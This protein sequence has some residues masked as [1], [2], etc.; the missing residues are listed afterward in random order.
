MGLAN[1]G[2]IVRAL[3][4][5]GM[6]PATPA[7]LIENGTLGNQRQVVTRLEALS[8]AGFRGPALI[9][10]GAVVALARMPELGRKLAA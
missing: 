1:L 2:A 5:A 9:V 4:S 8:S 6:D 3:E 10:I 7:C